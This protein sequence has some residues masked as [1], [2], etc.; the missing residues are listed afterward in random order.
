M[1]CF[2]FFQA[3]FDGEK[4][5]VGIEIMAPN[6][7]SL[8]GGSMWYPDEL[9]NAQMGKTQINYYNFVRCVDLS[10]TC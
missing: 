10:Q 5:V 2:C 6:G 3:T 9:N 8:G 7:E 1:F 4:H